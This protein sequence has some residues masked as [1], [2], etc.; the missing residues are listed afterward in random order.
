MVTV[1]KETSKIMGG[2][3]TVGYQTRMVFIGTHFDKQKGK[4]I[5]V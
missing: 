1:L 3:Q 2:I 5:S 4:T